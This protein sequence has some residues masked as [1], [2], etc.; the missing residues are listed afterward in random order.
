MTKNTAS[1][2][3]NLSPIYLHKLIYLFHGLKDKLVPQVPRQ[4]AHPLD[5]SAD[6]ALESGSYVA[7]HVPG[8]GLEKCIHPSVNGTARF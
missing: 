4:L 6:H 3:T 7:E 2:I 1:G 5:L 8:L